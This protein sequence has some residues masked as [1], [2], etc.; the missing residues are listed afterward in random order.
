MYLKTTDGSDPMNYSLSDSLNSRVSFSVCSL[1]AYSFYITHLDALY[2]IRL[3]EDPTRLVRYMNRQACMHT[4]VLSMTCEK[5]ETGFP[6]HDTDPLIGDNSDTRIMQPI[7]TTS[8][9]SLTYNNI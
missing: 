6:V 9:M 2:T 7:S 4:I 8:T 3:Y 5:Y 1:L